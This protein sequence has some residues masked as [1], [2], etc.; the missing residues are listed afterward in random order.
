MRQSQ[1]FIAEIRLA[2]LC[3][4][5]LLSRMPFEVSPRHG[6]LRAATES[7][8]PRVQPCASAAN[9]SCVSASPPIHNACTAF[10]DL[11]FPSA[12]VAY[13]D[14]VR[15]SREVYRVPRGLPVQEVGFSKYCTFLVLFLDAVLKS[16]K[17]LHFSELYFVE[18]RIVALSPSPKMCRVLHFSESSFQDMPSASFFVVFF[19]GF[20]PD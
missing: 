7:A 4:A 13:S 12:S 14:C 11:E 20:F 6:R 17:V 16:Y 15:L 10:L 19:F 8:L 18:V 2:V 3:R 1:I 9:I 5:P